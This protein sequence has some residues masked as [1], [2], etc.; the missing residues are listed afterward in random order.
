MKLFTVLFATVLISM[1]SGAMAADCVWPYVGV[2]GGGTMSSDNVLN[3][4]T[5]Y[6]V[7]GIVG[8]EY[9]KA[10]L[11]AEVSYQS[12][13]IDDVGGVKVDGDISLIS[14]ILNGYYEFDTGSKKWRPYVGA[15][16]G[17]GTAKTSSLVASGVSVSNRSSA[18]RFVYQ[19]TAGIGY[20]LTPHLAIDLSYRYFS[21]LKYELD[22]LSTNYTT[23]NM[24]VGARW[25]F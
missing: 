8:V 24:L 21:S 11:E 3:L 16:G 4:A 19:G 17:F 18:T 7:G 25:R 14:Y 20:F 13:K 23:H 5:G 2:T 15:G 6:T 1:T 12:A 10:R 9:C 22:N